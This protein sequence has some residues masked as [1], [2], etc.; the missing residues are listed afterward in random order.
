L[1]EVVER[2]H[3][4]DARTELL[5]GAMHAGTAL[6]LTG[7]ALA[8]AIAQVLGGRYDLPHGAMNALS[9]PPTLRFNQPVARDA[10]AAFGE[11]LGADDPAARV[12]E[13]ARL[14]GF[15]RLRDFGVPEEDLP[16]VAA[17]AAAR[18]GARAN[19]RSASPEDVLGLL[20]EM[21]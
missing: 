6:G 3:D 17:E 8:H 12:E 9:L 16:L 21:W 1:P 13:L 20:R 15:E 14:G 5:E 11:A 18:P 4:L 10:V 7:L 19:P 2:P